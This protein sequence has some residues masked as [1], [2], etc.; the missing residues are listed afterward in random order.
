MKIKLVRN[1]IPPK[2]AK[3]GDAGLDLMA[4]IDKPIALYPGEQKRIGTGLCMEIPEGCVGLMLPRSGLGIRGLTLINT[5][6]VIDSGY[7]GEVIAV[8]QNN[9]VDKIEIAPGDRFVQLLIMPF[10][11]V[12]IEVVDELSDTTRGTGGFGHSGV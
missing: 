5:C 9:G 8:C 11:R 3:I 1:G 7:R 12:P 10:C 2:Y 4:A 6:G